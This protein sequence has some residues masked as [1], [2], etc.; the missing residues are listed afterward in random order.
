MGLEVEIE[1]LKRQNHRLKLAMFSI[2][3]VLLIAVVAVAGFAG[4]A[5][6]RARAQEQRSACDGGASSRRSSSRVRANAASSR[7]NRGSALRL[8][9]S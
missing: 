1:A 4:V 6:S 9:V 8:A 5:A 3:A 7:N 2:I